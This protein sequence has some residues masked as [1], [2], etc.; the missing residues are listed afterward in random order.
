MPFGDSITDG[1]GIDGGYRTLLWQKLVRDEGARIDFVG[2]L[3]GGPSSLGDPDYEGHSGWCIDGDCYGGAGSQTLFKQTDSWLAAA[4]P[5]VILLHAGTNDLGS[6]AS[7]ATASARLDAELAKIYANLPD[8]KLV[9]AKN[10]SMNASGGLLTAYNGYIASMDDLATKYRNQGR[11]IT[12]VDMSTLLTYPADYKPGDYWH[13][14]QQGYDKM[15][16]AWYP[17]VSEYYTS[18]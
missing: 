14:N 18:F 2:S 8:V 12:V 15:A 5:D 6:G 4:R 1:Q 3:S 17:A 10:I 13:P 16:N 9:L 11:T 7:A